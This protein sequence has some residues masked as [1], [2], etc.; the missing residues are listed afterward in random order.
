MKT[1]SVIQKNLVNFSHSSFLSEKKRP[2]IYIFVNVDLFNVLHWNQLDK[3]WVFSDNY[4]TMS[5]ES[6]EKSRR[7][8]HKNLVNFLHS[9]FMSEKKMTISFTFVIFDQFNVSHWNQKEELWLF[10]ENN[11]KMSLESI[12]EDS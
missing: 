3:L 2:F 6:I 7:E 11:I 10:K 8:I 4:V 9:K 12:E 1:R 5:L